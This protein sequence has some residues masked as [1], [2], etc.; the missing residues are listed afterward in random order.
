MGSKDKVQARRLKG[1]QDYS[2]QIQYNR[3]HIMDLVRKHAGRA[4]FQPIATPALE[5]AD[6]LLGVGGETDKQ[7][8]RFQDNGKRDVALRF[9]L[10]VPFARY[11]AEYQGTILFPFKRMQIGDV[12]R[13]E[14]PQKGRYRE[15]CQC[16]LD[17]IGVQSD[18]ADL[19]ILLCFQSIL[20]DINCGP[21]TMRVGHR[22]ILSALIRQTLGNISDEE[23]KQTLICLDKLEKIGPEKVTEMICENTGAPHENAALLTSLLQD[24]EEDTGSHVPRIQEF[25]SGQHETLQ[26]L[27]NLKQLIN[28]AS[29]LGQGGRGR[30]LTD[31]SITRGLGYYT[32]LVFETTL[33]EL[34]G[35]G[36][37]CSGGRYQ[38]LVERYIQREISGIGGSLGLD[39]LL[40]A[41]QEMNRLLPDNIR[42]TVYV[43]IADTAFR[44]Y[45]FTLAAKLR[46]AGIATDLAMKADK[47]SSQFRHANRMKCPF[48]LTIGE[49]EVRNKTVS[50]KDM[51]TGA[52]EKGVTL[53][54]CV[55]YMSEKLSTNPGADKLL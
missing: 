2:P 39:R 5:Y 24:K 3:F 25:L 18:E 28:L 1:F 15:F 16:D 9:D 42:Q 34:P 48:V 30:V 49:E 37:V 45:G 7:V 51:A 14:K 12:W 55:A 31:L 36:A 10:T 4:G 52:E 46:Q 41:M 35:W 21:F 27:E 20:N 23:E 33:D 44:D 40:A 54:S 6:T 19:E 11:V 38:H 53:E 43:A 32:G 26:Q 13:A 29:Q 22:G 17:I 50:V 47:L 8:F